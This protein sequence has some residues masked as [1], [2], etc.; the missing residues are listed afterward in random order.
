MKIQIKNI[1]G[2]Q[3]SKVFALTFA[4]LM[5]PFSLMS[6]FFFFMMPEM[7]TGNGEVM[8]N[9]PFLFFAL[10]PVFYGVMFYFM[11]RLFCW[12]YNIVAK[13]V[14]GFEFETDE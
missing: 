10:A 14:G 5:L 9:F 6:V 3:T 12:A 1:S 13:R 11:Q 4:I 2:H 8:P 7:E